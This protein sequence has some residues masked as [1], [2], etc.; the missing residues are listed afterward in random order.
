MK[1]LKE[2]EKEIKESGAILLEERFAQN[3]EYII[4]IDFTRILKALRAFRYGKPDEIYLLL[5]KIPSETARKIYEKFIKIKNKLIKKYFYY[6]LNF[7]IIGTHEDYLEELYQSLLNEKK[8]WLEKLKP[9]LNEIKEK[10]KEKFGKEEVYLTGSLS[11]KSDNIFLAYE[12][13]NTE[14]ISSIDFFIKSEEIL[15][16]KDFEKELSLKKGFRI[17]IKYGKDVP[18]NAIPL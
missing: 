13:E 7:T 14:I 8:E 1:I 3:L 15:D 4:E 2:L 12:F 6:E 17:N 9:T 5:A 16:T 18:K 11:P 10:I